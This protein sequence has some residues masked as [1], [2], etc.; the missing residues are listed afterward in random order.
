MLNLEK[1]N[2]LKFEN[3]KLDSEKAY[4]LTGELVSNNPISLTE[5]WNLVGFIDDRDL[6][7]EQEILAIYGWDGEKYI[8]PSQIEKGK[9][10]WIASSG[11]III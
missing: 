10:Y 1:Q 5:G 8:C 7:T 2:Q 9:G 3:L 11:D 4:S 6:L